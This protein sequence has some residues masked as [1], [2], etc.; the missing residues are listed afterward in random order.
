MYNHGFPI[1]THTDSNLSVTHFTLHFFA[2]GGWNSGS[3]TTFGWWQDV[4]LT[5]EFT[6]YVLYST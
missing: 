6:Q 1:S 3:G 4:L 2:S 5:P